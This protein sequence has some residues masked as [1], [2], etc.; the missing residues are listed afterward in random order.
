MYQHHF[1]LK[2]RPFRLVPDPAYLF[3]GGSQREAM[4]HLAYA[5]QSGDGFATLIGEVGC[6][7]TT[8]C[9]AFLEQLDPGV[10]S[11]YIFNPP[12]DPLDLM[13]SVNRDF[14]L[15]KGGERLQDLVEELNRFLIGEKAAGRTAL[16][17]IDEAQRL[18]R[19]VLEQIRLLSNLETTRSKLLLIILA[20]QP[21]L[22]ATL[23][24]HELR[25]LRQ[26]IT[27]SCRLKPLTAAETGAYIRHRLALAAAGVPVAFTAAALRVIFAFSKG[28]PRRIN[29]GCDRALICAYASGAGRVDRAMAR[30]AVRELQTDAPVRSSRPWP[31]PVLLTALLAALLA[32]GLNL[33]VNRPAERNLARLSVASRTPAAA[34]ATL[35]ETAAAASVIHQDP[36]AL[37]RRQALE[38]LLALWNLAAVVPDRSPADDPS[39]LEAYC[40]P[41][42]LAV[43]PVDDLPMVERL[44]LPAILVLDR[45]EDRYGVLCSVQAD[46]YLLAGARGER[47]PL[48]HDG[49]QSTWTGKAYVL[50][51]DYYAL[52]GRIPGEAGAAAVLNLKTMLR[53][54]GYT[55]IDRRAGFD[56]ATRRA[57]VD[58][59][60]RVGL[61]ADGVVGPQTK[62]ALYNTRPELAIP[63]LRP[64][65]PI[66]RAVPRE[67]T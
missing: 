27:V 67:A 30:R 64:L 6:G 31:S 62:I 15:E 33:K 50:W 61:P 37:D 46:R 16:L 48:T 2:E 7:K 36:W 12:A 40:E 65:A 3:M 53:E 4:A 26:R 22:E 43:Y 58:F 28:I 47:H 13:R 38:A 14:G 21:E 66:Q 35:Q 56:D 1:G 32:L 39:F 63:L 18:D 52:S 44:N 51:R 23:A 34:P 24:A 10:N 25:Q 55:D 8:L 49:L 54:L 5:V 9:R 11:A 19:A 45:S 57:V 42:G 29:L 17:M 59:Q 20:G 60:T 41:L